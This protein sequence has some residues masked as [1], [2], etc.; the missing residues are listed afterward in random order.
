MT[1][2]ERVLRLLT[3]HPQIHRPTAGVGWWAWLLQRIT[4]VALVAYLFLHIGVISTSL[5]G[6]D[7]FDPVLRLLQTPVF[8]VLDLLLVATVLYH[9]L[10]G[11]RVIFF[12]MG[13]GIK[14]QAFLFWVALTT[15]AA[16]MAVAVYF[17][18]PLI[19]K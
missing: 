6:A 8:V 15:T 12:D 16:T 7:N 3:L 14:A 11:I 10:N 18:M 1:S 19:L 13:I 5:G 17:S 2:Q 9:T 4:G